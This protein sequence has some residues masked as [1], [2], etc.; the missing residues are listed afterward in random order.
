MAGEMY[1]GDVLTASCEGLFINMPPDYITNY[2]NRLQE[3]DGAG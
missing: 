2:H 1:V 3:T